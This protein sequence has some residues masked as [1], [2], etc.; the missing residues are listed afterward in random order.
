MRL[1]REI[2]EDRLIRSVSMWAAVA[3]TPSYEAADTVLAFV[4]IDGEPDTDPLFARLERDGKRL[5]LPA[6]IDDR[7]VPMTVGAGLAVGPY[8]VPVPQGD[9]VPLGEL[10]LVIVP[11]LAFTSDG[12]RLG[13]GGGHYDRFLAALPPSCPVIGVCFSEQIVDELPLEPHDHR[14]GQVLTDHS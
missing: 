7:I 4:G 11:G 1:V 9:V 8:G 6:M 3:A 10:G 2:V 12:G 5:V 14:V 13:R